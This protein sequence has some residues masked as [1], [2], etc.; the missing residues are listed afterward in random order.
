MDF[1]RLTIPELEQ[2]NLTL[3]PDPDV[4]RTALQQGGGKTRFYIGCAKWG[5]KE[6]V[7]KLYPRGTKEK[8]FLSLYAQQFNSLEFNGFFYNKHSR[9]QVEKWAAMAPEGFLFCPKFTQSITHYKRLKNTGPDVDEFLH[10]VTGFG[11][12][13]GPLF[14]MPAPNMGPKTLA[15]IEQFIA[16]F[17][18][19]VP[20]FTEFRHKD[21]FVVPEG[22]KS[23]LYSMLQTQ[24]RGLVI[25][26]T[27]GRR[28]CAH[29][30]LTTPE[31]FIRFVGNGLHP[32]DY[33]RIDDWVNRLHQW[34]NAGLETCYFF[35][36]QHNE[37]HS[38]ELIRYFINRLNATC[39]T[40][41]P[42]PV[43]Y[44]ADSGE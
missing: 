35:M 27:A 39:G 29:M 37:L 25:T 3:P 2:T 26:D 32:T 7:G 42:L 23:D 31:C 21:W 36:H 9:E 40:N 30:H 43:W 8:D 12:R 17:P 18:E 33:S 16:D 24:R 10:I 19:D 22:L 4:T 6:W 44:A 13:L 1:G 34:M 41:I 5:R 11:P 20:L 28:D 15:V 14:L 38:P